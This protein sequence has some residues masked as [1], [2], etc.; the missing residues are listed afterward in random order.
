MTMM[1]DW[2]WAA[3]AVLLAAA[4]VMLWIGLA[5]RQASVGK[6]PTGA[7][8]VVRPVEAPTYEQTLGRVVHEAST[9]GLSTRLEL[10][11]GMTVVWAGS[12]D[13]WRPYA[14]VDWL[15]GREAA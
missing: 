3:S 8:A 6:N 15:G 1:N 12:G 11:I 5:G 13:R 7:D 14:R 9:A 4:M 10:G 2:A